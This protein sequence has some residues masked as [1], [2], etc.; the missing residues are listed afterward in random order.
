MDNRNVVAYDEKGKAVYETSSEISTL[1]KQNRELMATIQQLSQ[2]VGQLQRDVVR[3][4]LV[5]TSLCST[6]RY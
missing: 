3:L 4:D 2:V 1:E 5:V 6:R